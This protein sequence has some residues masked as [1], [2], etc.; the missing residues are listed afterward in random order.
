MVV[1]D[2]RELWTDESRDIIMSAVRVVSIMLSRYT[3]LP[4]DE[5]FAAVFGTIKM[6]FT[7]SLATHARAQYD[8]IRFQ[9]NE[10]ITLALV[11]HE[12]GHMF[13]IRAKNRPTKRLWDDRYNLDTRAASSWLGKHPPSLAGYNVVEQFCNAWELL[14]MGLYADN[15]AARKLQTWFATYLADWCKIAMRIV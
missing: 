1:F 15:E 13:G 11:I 8:V 2:Q 10:V 9:N 5:A 14:V 7:P 12:L 3:E 6:R 4:P